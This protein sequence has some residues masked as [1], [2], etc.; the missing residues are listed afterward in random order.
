VEPKWV[1][2]AYTELNRLLESLTNLLYLIEHDKNEPT[3]IEHYVRL[4][5]QCVER[6]RIIVV[7]RLRI[8]SPY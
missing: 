6:A 3:K 2:P 7:D 4:A 1:D 8:F 5:G